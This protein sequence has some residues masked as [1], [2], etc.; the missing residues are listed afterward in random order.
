M[1]R[2]EVLTAPLALIKVG[3]RVIGKMRN[4]S[5][6]ES[7]RRGKVTG[8]GR[9]NASEAPAL[10]FDSNMNCGFYT[11]DFSRHPL[12][13]DALLRRTG[14]I[15]NFINTMILQE[16]GLT[17]VALRKIAANRTN[18]NEGRN[19]NGIIVVDDETGYEEFA[20]IGNCFITGDNF[21]INEGQISNHNSTFMVLDP[22]IYA[23]E[24]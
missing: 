22:I 17:V 23:V 2:Q 12:T 24:G 5:V 3:D 9:L 14:S 16:I 10:E 20:I 15:E 19:E 21:D 7:Y 4:I 11:I 1:A 8:I 6:Q 18:N 13:R